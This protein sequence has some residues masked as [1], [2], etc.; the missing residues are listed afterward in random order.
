MTT[1]ELE[2]Q[3]EMKDIGLCIPKKDAESFISPLLY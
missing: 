2:E 1:F 3:R